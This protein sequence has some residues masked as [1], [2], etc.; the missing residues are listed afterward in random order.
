[1]TKI[2]DALNIRISIPLLSPDS[3]TIFFPLTEEDYSPQ[4][5]RFINGRCTH[6][7]KDVVM[8]CHE[9][10]FGYSFAVDP[11]NP[12]GPYVKKS[13]K[14]AAHDGIILTGPEE[15][16]SG[17][18]YQKLVDTV[19]ENETE[20]IRVLYIGKVLDICYLK[21]H[22]IEGRFLI[23][24]NSVQIL[25]TES[26]LSKHEVRDIAKMCA[27]IGMEYGEIDVMRDRVDG[28]IYVIDMNRTPAGPPLKFSATERKK[29]IGKLADAFEDGFGNRI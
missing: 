28:R 21:R 29:V 23:P 17:F 26:L 22:P 12:I 3:A 25:Q 20:E 6:I 18:V 13:I 4:P 10:A 5:A 1:M 14:N 19:V 27:L 16:K 24:S 8:Q 11:L 15:P 9:A 2:C 7:G